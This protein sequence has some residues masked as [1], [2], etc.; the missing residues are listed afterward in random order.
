MYYAIKFGWVDVKD[1]NFSNS[2]LDI[3][4]LNREALRGIYEVTAI[5]S[6]YILKYGT[7]MHFLEL[8]PVLEMGTAPRLLKKGGGG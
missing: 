4:T 5:V 2:A 7:I 6:V 8:Q 1:Y 3:E